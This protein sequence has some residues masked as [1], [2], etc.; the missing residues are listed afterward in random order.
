MWGLAQTANTPPGEVYLEETAQKDYQHLLNLRLDYDLSSP[1]INIY[2][3]TGAYETYLNPY[4]TL[5]GAYTYYLKQTNPL[6][7]AVE[8][9]LRTD[10]ISQTILTPRYSFGAYSRLISLRGFLNLFSKAVPRAEVS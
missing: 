7:V 8:E 2:G 9:N 6:A 3:L 5:G 4:L 1:Y 10:K